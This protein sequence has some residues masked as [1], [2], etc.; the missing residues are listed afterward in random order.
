MASSESFSPPWPCN[1]GVVHWVMKSSAFRQDR[2]EKDGV[3][4]AALQPTAT[5]PSFPLFLSASCLIL[6]GVQCLCLQGSKCNVRM[7]AE[8]PNK[9]SRSGL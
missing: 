4:P 7:I 5:W 8:S 9:S 3:H 6:D 1:S 2:G